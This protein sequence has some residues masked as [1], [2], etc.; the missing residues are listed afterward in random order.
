MP[1]AGRSCGHDASRLFLLSGI[2]SPIG[3]TSHSTTIARDSENPRHILIHATASQ[4]YSPV[5]AGSSAAL[6]LE[7]GI[8][9]RIDL[10]AKSTEQT[11]NGQQV[12]LPS[13]TLEN[14]STRFT[15]EGL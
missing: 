7:T 6:K 12:F 9:M 2:S 4:L 5:Q 14:A 11:V 1:S 10:D 8:T 15:T 13:F 3:S